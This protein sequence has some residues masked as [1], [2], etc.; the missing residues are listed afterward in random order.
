M[1][2]GMVIFNRPEQPENAASPMDVTLSGMAMLVRFAQPANDSYPM[3][4][5]LFGI[6]ILVRLIQ[7]K[8]AI[9]PILVVLLG[10]LSG[11]AMAQNRIATVDLSKVFDGYWKTKA[12]KDALKKSQADMEK[13]LKDM[14]DEFQHARDDYQKLAAAATEDTISSQERDRRKQT[15][16][17]KLKDVKEKQDSIVRYQRQ[18]DASLEEQSHRMRDNLIKDIR[19]VVNAR[20]KAG[21][22]GLVL[23]SAAKGTSD[24]PFVLFNAGE[25]DITDQALTQLNAAAPAE[26]KSDSDKPDKK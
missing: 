9:S 18:K 7:S 8:N 25:S 24:T 19:D 21:G 23:D 20:A 2:S 6:V 13:T 16:E 4:T 3:L 15:A 10:M 17:D 22:Y 1:L 12:A 11:T 14:Q 26:A 5:I